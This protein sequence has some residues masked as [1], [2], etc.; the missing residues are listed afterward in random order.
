M[1]SPAAVDTLKR[2]RPEWTPW[3]AVV[4]YALREAASDR[5]DRAV[6]ERPEAEGSDPLLSGASIVVD[7]AAVRRL[8]ERLIKVSSR[9][10]TPK[11]ATLQRAVRREVDVAGL[12]AASICQ[13]EDRIAE[14]AATSIADPEALQAVVALVAL[15]FLYACTRRWG[16]SVPQTWA[17]GY[18]P[19]CGSWPAFAELRGIERSRYLRCGRC[20][21]EWHAHMLRCAYCANTNH[22]DLASLVPETI[23]S[24]GS[25]DACRRCHGYVKAFTRLQGCPPAAVMLEDLASVDLDLAALAQGYTRRAGAGTPID[26]TV[27]TTA[28]R[29]FSWKS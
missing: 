20:G 24:S 25:I 2:D 3:L 23:G 1:S 17:R 9:E 15:P 13:D 22:D 16:A 12:F 8:L 28:P 19:V 18:C 27:V 14:A 5:W 10:G 6:P 7:E 21:G 11:M 29:F 4:E 26:L